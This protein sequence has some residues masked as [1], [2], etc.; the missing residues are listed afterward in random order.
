VH[1][2]GKVVPPITNIGELYQRYEQGDWIL[3]TDS[4]V[5][6]LEKDGRFDKVYYKAIQPELRRDATGGLFHKSG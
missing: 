3:A 5:N 1:Y 6:D 2:Y 4:D